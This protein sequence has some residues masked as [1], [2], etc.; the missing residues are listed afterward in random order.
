MKPENGIEDRIENYSEENSWE[1]SKEFVKNNLSYLSSAYNKRNQG[2]MYTIPQEY[3]NIKNSKVN[4]DYKEGETLGEENN[5][6]LK[7]IDNIEKSN[8][9]IKS[10]LIE[11]EK[12]TFENIKLSEERNEKRFEQILDRIKESDDRLERRLNT[13]ATEIKEQTK[14]VE[15]RNK[16][17]IDDL[18][19]E[20]RNTKGWIIG[21]S[22]GI[23]ALCITTIITIAIA[24][25]K[26]PK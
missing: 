13:L 5:T 20:Y 25:L 15:N 1:R 2:R 4:N 17:S 6:L 23:L 11:S 3:Y 12:R 14:E 7:L 9:Q 10:D 21:A 24:F 22:V 16:I 18:K 19:Q 26:V 8:Q